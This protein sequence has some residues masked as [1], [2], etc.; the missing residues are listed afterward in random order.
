MG[1]NRNMNKFDNILN[2]TG[3]GIRS[4]VGSLS[5]ALIGDSSSEREKRLKSILDKGLI[6][7]QLYNYLISEG[8]LLCPA[9]TRY[10][11]NYEGG[12]FDHCYAFYEALLQLTEGCGLEWAREE[13]IANIAFGHDVCKLDNYVATEDGK[14]GYNENSC[15][16]G[17][18]EKSVILLQQVMDMTEEEVY[19]VLYH[20]GAYETDRWDAFSKGIDKYPNVLFTHTADMIA[21]KIVGV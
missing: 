2:S 5:D 14:Y 18:G 3:E 16:H 12:L 17:H 13:S 7:E 4:F 15:L 21:S 20:M 6:D 1:R 19:C 10:H 9:S 8:F 11:G